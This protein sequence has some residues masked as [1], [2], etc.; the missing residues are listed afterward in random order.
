[1][2]DAKIT[3][4]DALTTTNAAD[5]VAVVDDV[6]VTPITKKV[7]LAKLMAG[8]TIDG[9]LTSNNTF[10]AEHLYSTDDAVIDDDLSVGGDLTVTG[11][12]KNQSL[13]NSLVGNY[14]SFDGTN[15]IFTISDDDDI[16]VGVSDF[17]IVIRFRA[18]DVS[19]TEYLINKE[20]SG[21]GYG[22]YKT[23]DDIYIRF[24]D[25]NADASG[26]ILTAKFVAEEWYNLVVTFD[27]DGDATAHLN[28][29]TGT[30]DISGTPLTLSNAGNLLIGSTTAGASFFKGQIAH[31]LLFN[32]LFT[33]D[34]TL[35]ALKWDSDNPPVWFSDVGASS[36]DILS[37]W[38]FTSGWSTVGATSIDDS[39]SFTSPSAS[40][41]IFKGNIGLTAGKQYRV[42]IEGSTGTSGITVG[43][44]GGSGAEYGTG[45]GSHEFTALS[46]GI[47]IKTTDAGTT[48]ITTFEAIQIGN[49]ANYNGQ[50][51]TASTWHDNSGNDLDGTVTGATLIRNTDVGFDNL[52]VDGNL[53]VIGTTINMV[54]SMAELTVGVGN[55][56]GTVSAGV[57]TDRTP[58][59]DGD[60]LT[61]IKNIKGKNG[62][63][64]HLS[65][66]DFVQSHKTK[67][68]FESQ[69]KRD[70]DGELV[71]D[72][73]DN[74]VYEDV[75][76]G[77]E[78]TI[79]RNIGN[80]ISVNV[81]AIQQLL[82]RVEALE[83][84]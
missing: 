11:D 53:T 8:I 25:N 61:A 31:T 10:Q 60:A 57:F 48:D 3:Q 55:D 36:T 73:D 5:L 66:P 13:Q 24:D 18:D 82:E 12:L 78:P 39:D 42:I 29:N 21:V 75:K 14:Y 7:T 37:G 30:V 71:K 44:E 35:E 63:I 52:F 4:L 27:R 26:L 46:N 28:G 32:R 79:E 33:S 43:N 19:G 76:V 50:G 9:A 2:A 56:N 22:I 84:A 15:D 6:A 68:T 62:Q 80:M 69:K 51:M 1:M 70:E 81:K 17:S 23:D 38:D 67:D 45:F 54:T 64:D 77:E 34:E 16:D 49:V 58:F 72:G 65:L 74:Q 41:G 47:W 59:Y 83:S 40:G 20:D